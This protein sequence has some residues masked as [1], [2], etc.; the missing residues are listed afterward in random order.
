MT[1][2][3]IGEIGIIGLYSPLFVTVIPKRIGI[4]Q[5]RWAL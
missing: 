5:R 3:F 4:S 2:N 1:T